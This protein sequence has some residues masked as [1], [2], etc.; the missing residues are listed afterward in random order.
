MPDWTRDIERA[1]APLNLRPEREREIADELAA[2]LEDR[3]SDA[4]GRGATEEAA[5]AEAV[6]ELGT[7]LVPELRRVESPW[8]A[9]EPLGNPQRLTLLEMMRRDVSYALRSLRRTPGFTA[10]SLLTLAIGIGACTLI[11]SAVNAVL[12]RPLPYRAPERLAVF[13]GTAPEKGLPEVDIPEGLAAVYQSQTRTLET[14]A[15]YGSTGFN[16]TGTE[17]AER[18]N[19]AQVSLDFFK[20]LGVAPLL[21]RVPVLGE[22]PRN[23]PPSVIVLS[24]ALWMRRFGGDSS[25]VGRKVEVSGAPVTVVG[26]MPPRFDFPYRSEAWVPFEFDAT[27]FSCWCFSTIGRMRAG[28]TVEDVRREIASINDEF[29]LVRRD[30][31]PTARRGGS[32]VVA[33]TLSERLVGGIE[34]QLL[35]LLAAVGCVLLIACANIANLLL[36]RTAARGRELA[37]RCCLGASPRR[38]AAQLLTESVLLSFGGAAL[39]ALLAMWGTSALRRLPTAQFPRIDEVRV[40]VVVLAVTVGVALITGLLC[41][42]VP[43]WRATRVDLQDA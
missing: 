26:V 11:L 3:Y 35:T 39:G 40:D 30:V 20:T 10:V 36:A 25:L 4:K 13:W 5:K 8:H 43:A 14:F 38:I 31:F 21:G 16:L 33:M 12:V 41:G 22:D 15:A 6:A 37:V 34:K 7:V 27:R 32:R 18:V 29:G 2:H 23:A 17:G 24:H 19:G 1:L 9:A 28:V 42:L